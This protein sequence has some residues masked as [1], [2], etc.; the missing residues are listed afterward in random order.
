MLII[1]YL[2]FNLVFVSTITDGLCVHFLFTGILSSNQIAPVIDHVMLALPV[3]W[4]VTGV[5]VM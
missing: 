1:S 4:S 5:I 2:M 3:V